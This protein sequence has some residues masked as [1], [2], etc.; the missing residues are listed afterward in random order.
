MK[1][2][3]VAGLGLAISACAADPSNVLIP[4]PD[5]SQPP[6]ASV[7]PTTATVRVGGTV[8]VKASMTPCEGLPVLPVFRF[9]SNDTL[10][11]SVD[12]ITGLVLARRPGTANIIAALV[13]DPSVG[14]TMTLLVA[15]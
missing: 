5:C 11:A 12:P 2:I 13:G 9:F 15:P 4:T 1:G 14:G 7:S 3:L 8:R 10:T 6:G